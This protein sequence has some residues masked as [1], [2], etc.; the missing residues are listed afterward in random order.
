[1]RP[2]TN[3]KDHRTRY[4]VRRL[5]AP[6]KKGVSRPPVV[7]QHHGLDRARLAALGYGLDGPTTEGDV[8]TGTVEVHRIQSLG[9][10]V[11]RSELVDVIDERVAF[12]LM[13]RPTLPRPSDL[14][15]SVERLQSEANALERLGF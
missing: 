7:E 13:N 3:C 15:V 6:G 12:R 14:S 1:M 11:L 9:T 2:K 4:E 8:F 10:L 5:R